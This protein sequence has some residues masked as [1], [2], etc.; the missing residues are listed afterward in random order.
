MLATRYVA[1]SALV[2]AD[3]FLHHA[4]LTG[5][6]LQPALGLLRVRTALSFQIKSTENQPLVVL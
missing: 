6:I 5:G 4:H 1:P 2:V 3:N